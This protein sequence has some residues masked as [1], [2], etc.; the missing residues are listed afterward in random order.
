MTF[1]GLDTLARLSTLAAANA[2]WQGIALTGLAWILLR[3]APRT[4]A[5]TRYG[6]WW[7]TLAAV[8]V[9]PFLYV[10]GK[11]VDA[12]PAGDPSS[13]EL[14]PRLAAGDPGGLGRPRHS[15]AR[16]A[17]LELRLC[18][19]AG[20]Y[21]DSTPHVLA[22][23]RLSSHPIAPRGGARLP[24]DARTGG[25]RTLEELDSNTSRP[26]RTAQPGGSRTDHPPR[27]GPYSP[28]GQ[29]DELCL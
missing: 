5:A 9:L 19:L 1:D 14:F 17:R 20:A 7:A 12:I 4:S 23:M 22:A 15:D 21:F 10:A 3:Y 26:Y 11:S 8:V 2:F 29:L 6:I 13:L 27:M 16:T 28:P 25:C 24:R 18:V